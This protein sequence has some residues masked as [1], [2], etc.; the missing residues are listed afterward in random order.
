MAQDLESA[1]HRD[2]R[3]FDSKRAPTGPSYDEDDPESQSLEDDPRLLEL[4]K[5][6]ALC[7]HEVLGVR[8]DESRGVD[9]ADVKFVVVVLPLPLGSKYNWRGNS[10]APVEYCDFLF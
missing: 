8:Y 6:S 10:G 3:D 5:Q 1:A 4:A 9:I 7:M 2:E